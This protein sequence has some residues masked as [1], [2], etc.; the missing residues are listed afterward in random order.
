[1]K[2][3]L[4]TE[5]ELKSCLQAHLAGLP[6]RAEALPLRRAIA[7]LG[8]LGWERENLSAILSADPQNP[9]LATAAE[10]I[11]KAKIPYLLA[12]SGGV[13]PL[14]LRSMTPE[15]V[16]FLDAPD[17]HI[18]KRLSRFVSWLGQEMSAGENEII[19][20][21]NATRLP[22]RIPVNEV[23]AIHAEGDYAV[24]RSSGSSF[25]LRTSLS[26]IML[27]LD[28][29]Q[30]VRI[31]RTHIVARDAIEQICHRGQQSLEVRL[32]N[33]DRLPIGRTYKRRL[34]RLLSDHLDNDVMAPEAIVTDS[35]ASTGNLAGIRDGIS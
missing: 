3:L 10:K 13:T 24:I 21:T 7:Q 28:P 16:I 29:Q 30:F 23:E 27:T 5:E 26:R 19:V 12:L 1:M 2:L 6:L 15:D 17:D 8:K 34:K 33:G 9:D 32:R 31:H 11:Q 22:I 4:I 14:G 35:G 20:R 18:R 25:V